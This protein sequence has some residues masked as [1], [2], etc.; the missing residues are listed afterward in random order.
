MTKIRKIFIG[1][2]QALD[3][4][5]GLNINMAPWLLDF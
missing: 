1:N 2:L 5:R 3:V 4:T